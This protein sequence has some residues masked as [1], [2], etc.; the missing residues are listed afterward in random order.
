MVPDLAGRLAGKRAETTTLKRNKVVTF[1]QP[2][3]IQVLSG[4]VWLTGTPGDV[5][6]ILTEGER[7]SLAGC[8]P[9]VAE[10]LAEAEIA[11]FA[12]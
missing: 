1:N 8:F 2:G 12:D 3:L 6:V 7:F 10:G 4:A 9:F 11:F 5:D